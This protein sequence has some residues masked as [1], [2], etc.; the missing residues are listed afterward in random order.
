MSADQERLL[1][2]MSTSLSAIRKKFYDGC[3]LMSGGKLNYFK[4]REEERKVLGA[5]VL[6]GLMKLML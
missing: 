3:D 4:D 1:G 5:F 6:M 2:T